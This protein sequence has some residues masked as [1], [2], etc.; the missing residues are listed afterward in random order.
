MTAT[1]HIAREQAAG[2]AL[3]QPI[4]RD[5]LARPAEI[6]RRACAQPCL[7]L[8]GR[9]EALLTR[10][11]TW[12]RGSGCKCHP[13][14]RGEGP[15]GPYLPRLKPTGLPRITT[16]SSKAC[17]DRR[18][19]EAGRGRANIAGIAA[20]CVLVAGVVAFIANFSTIVTNTR[21]FLGGSDATGAT[22]APLQESSA[23]TS[24]YP[25]VQTP[26]NF[27]SATPSANDSGGVVS[28]GQWYYLVDLDLVE[29]EIE[30]G[31]TGGCA[32]FDFSSARIINTYPQSVITRL[33]PQGNRSVT[34]WN[35]LKTCSTFE[36]TVGLS[37]RSDTAT[38]IFT[39]D[40]DGSGPIVVA[41]VSTGME[42]AVRIDMTNAYRFELAANVTTEL[43]SNASLD[44]VWGD[45]RLFCS[46][47]IS[48]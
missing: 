48:D 22:T 1:T 15:G 23:P 43:P 13:A 10:A 24:T 35:A 30:V 36:A 12:W 47:D 4:V 21:D 38:A 14:S 2:L 17:Q 41:E 33:R 32:N 42:Q 34:T 28:A 8:D 6:G 27:P 19:T 46:A 45:A 20:I 25:S 11:V 18:M 26:S 3:Y 44:A 40:K 16:T 7:T 5:R 39:I 37:D 9:I 29:Q 31:C